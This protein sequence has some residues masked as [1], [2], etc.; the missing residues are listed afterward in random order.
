RT[1]DA[2]PRWIPLFPD[3]QHFRPTGTGL[4]WK[5]PAGPVVGIAG[6]PAS[7]LTGG[8]LCV[9]RSELLDL[10]FSTR[11]GKGAGSFRGRCPHPA[12]STREERFKGRLPCPALPGI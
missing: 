10:A 5:S 9:H 7:A 2:R 3:V 1:V 4:R 11:L 6:P 8:S 12:Q